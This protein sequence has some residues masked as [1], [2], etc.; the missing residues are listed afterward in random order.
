MNNEINFNLATEELEANSVIRERI[1]RAKAL[2]KNEVADYAEK[3]KMLREI[4]KERNSA[5]RKYERRPNEKNKAVMIAVCKEYDE[6]YKDASESLE[7]LTKYIAT[8]EKDWNKLIMQISILD[9]RSVPKE[10]NEFYRFK[11]S[12]ESE[13]NKAEELL[14]GAG[15]ELGNY[16]NLGVVPVSA[17]EETDTEAIPVSDPIAT[18]EYYGTPAQVA[19][20]PRNVNPTCASYQSPA[21][22]PQGMPEYSPIATVPP[23]TAV[24]PIQ[25][26]AEPKAPEVPINTSSG[27]PVSPQRQGVNL[28]P[29]TLDISSYVEKAV[30][31]AIDKMEAALEKRIEE[32]F[33]TYTPKIPV[34][35]II[36]QLATAPEAKTSETA[37]KAE[38]AEKTEAAP[39]KK[40][41]K[42]AP[43]AKAAET[44]PKAEVAEKTEAAPA[45]K[46]EKPAPEAKAVETA[47]KAE[48]AE[49]TEAAPAQKEEKPAPEAKA[50]ETAPK[51]EVAENV[52]TVSK[53][54]TDAEPSLTVPVPA[55]TVPT[56]G[57]SAECVALQ[58]KVADDEKFILDKL[59]AIVE[60]LKKL[61]VD[62]TNISSV[63]ADMDTKFH[64]LAELQRQTNDM[65]RHTL[66]EQQGVQV[67]QKVINRDQLEITEE[68]LT[69]A[70]LQK[71][72]LEEHKR[73]SEAQNAVAE[74][75]QAVVET[76]ASIEEAMRGVLQEQ[77]RIVTAQQAI[78]TENSRQVETHK[79]IAEQQSEVAE[80]Q[81]TILATQRGIVREQK[82][83]SERQ[84]ETVDMQKTVVEEVKEV[85]REQKGVGV[86]T[87]PKTPA[88]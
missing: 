4:A 22:V 77:K 68:Q 29:I 20:M 63:Y 62:I 3:V 84:R 46:E 52:P 71:K 48:V 27:V 49:K 70:D 2:I 28:A 75:Q 69:L 88:N 6:Y 39:A 17:S 13:K 81:K 23:A 25:Q 58:E 86:K 36:S 59:V 60:V 21:Y 43:E 1:A 54:A 67:N 38:V 61:N 33:K 35:D 66:R 14:R 85:M 55:M 19:Y 10:Q 16:E 78:A 72:A 44:A 64:E 24:P 47:P 12:F 56:S 41:E 76:Q 57:L 8:V 87:K 82:N 45:Q 42:P 65:Q 32:F 51:A 26:S 11:K 31:Q 73:I 40:E 5:I 50:V 79:R 80:E 7:R 34:A 53:A 15:I 83:T 9:S 74:T 30:R 18:A 37:P